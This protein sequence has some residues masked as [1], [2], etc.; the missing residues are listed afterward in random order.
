MKQIARLFGV[1]V[2]VS[3]IALMAIAPASAQTGYESIILRVTGAAPTGCGIGA[4][5]TIFGF[6]MEYDTPVGLNYTITLLSGPAGASGSGS[7]SLPAG[8]GTG[9]LVFTLNTVVTPPPWS[10]TIQLDGF[11]GGVQVTTAT[12]RIDCPAGVGPYSAT[13][14]SFA[15]VYQMPAVAGCDSYIP[16][17][18][19]SVVGTFVQ[20]TPLYWQPNADGLTN[21]VIESGKSY[22]VLGQDESGA[23]YRVIIGC[24]P[25]WVPVS[26]VGPNYDDIWGGRPLPTNVVS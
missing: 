9:T 24:S 26:A 1:V 17:T 10:L 3:L 4:P 25:A 23:Y 5:T 2:L 18:A 15:N 16:L 22:W 21:I 20:T 7:G 19:S 6:D 8:S 11:V 12:A 14:L 13:P